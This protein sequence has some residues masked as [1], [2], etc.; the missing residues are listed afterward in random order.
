MYAKLRYVA[1][2]LIALLCCAA[3]NFKT[4]AQ[5][6]AKSGNEP[7]FRKAI[8]TSVETQLKIFNVKHADAEQLS[9]TIRPLFIPRPEATTIIVFDKRTNTV[10]ARGPES[11]LSV[12]ELVLLRLD[13]PVASK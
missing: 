1:I 10:I 2:A 4:T 3:V 5:T 6:D 13:E 8:P 7:Q 11:E 9:S 12:L